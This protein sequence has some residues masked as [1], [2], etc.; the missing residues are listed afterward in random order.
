MKHWLISLMLCG[1][2]AHAH[3]SEPVIPKY[4]TQDY[5][6]YFYY[7]GDEDSHQATHI[8]FGRSILLF[9]ND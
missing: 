7:V 9:T 8:R 2:T 6:V 1:A 5:A 4:D 3:Q